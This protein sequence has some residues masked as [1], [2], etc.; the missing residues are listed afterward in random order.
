[1]RIETSQIVITTEERLDGD[2]APA[3]GVSWARYS[4]RSLPSTGTMEGGAST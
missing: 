2:K 3:A 4:K 1:M